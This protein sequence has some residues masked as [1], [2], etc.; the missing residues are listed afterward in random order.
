MSEKIEL[1][2]GFVCLREDGIMH[3]H[4]AYPGRIKLPLALEFYEARKQLSNDKIYPI[5]YTAGSKLLRPSG[6]VKK[7]MASLTRAETMLADAFVVNTIFQRFLGN[8]YL[9]FNKPYHPTAIFHK[10]ENAISWLNRFV[11]D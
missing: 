9:V 11:Q 8:L 5:L 4:I 3:V 7:H 6:A 10:Q 2:Y 1:A